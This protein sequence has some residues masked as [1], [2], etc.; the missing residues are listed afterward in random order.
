M[1]ISLRYKEF[2]IHEMIRS[3]KD[4]MLEFV[5]SKESS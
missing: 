2:E 1:S 4:F 5:C 3:N